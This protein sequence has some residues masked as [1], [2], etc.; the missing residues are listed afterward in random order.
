VSRKEN[1]RVGKCMKYE[2]EAPDQEAEQRGTGEWKEV[3]HK[4]CQAH[5]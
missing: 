2:V 4:D 5:N 1:D 3:V